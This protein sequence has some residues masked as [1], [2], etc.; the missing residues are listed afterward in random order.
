MN[1]NIKKIVAAIAF[2]AVFIAAF[3]GIHTAFSP[4]TEQGTKAFSLI[5]T[6][7]GGKKTEYDYASDAEFVGEALKE[8]EKDSGFTM[9]GEDSEYGFFISGINGI[10][11]DYDKDGAYWAFYINGEYAALGIDKQPLTDGDQIELRYEK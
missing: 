2:F 9:E 3:W 7:D 8:M 4:K 10:V 5:V 1:K 11:A 6:D